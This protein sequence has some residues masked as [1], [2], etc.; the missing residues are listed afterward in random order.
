M[1]LSVNTRF[2]CYVHTWVMGGVDKAA[3]AFEL[4]KAPTNTSSYGLRSYEATTE[5][6]AVKAEAEFLV[7]LS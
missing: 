4:V 1:V 5:L 6:E 7:P 2:V 3:A